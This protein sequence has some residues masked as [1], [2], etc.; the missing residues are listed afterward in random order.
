MPFLTAHSKLPVCLQGCEPSVHFGFRGQWIFYIREHSRTFFSKKAHI[1]LFRPQHPPCPGHPWP[2][3]MVSPLLDI[4]HQCSRAACGFVTS[5]STSAVRRLSQRLVG[6]SALITSCCTDSRVH[7]HAKSLQSCPALCDP[8]TCSPPGSQTTVYFLMHQPMGV[9][10]CPPSDH[11]EQGCCVQEGPVLIQ[12][13]VITSL[14]MHWG[15]EW[16]VLR[17][18]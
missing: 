12:M 17:R 11:C 14:G 13:S 7:V 8:M 9:G 16:R 18:P 10:L 3:C 2:V 6:A 1:P 5:S 4:S 15:V